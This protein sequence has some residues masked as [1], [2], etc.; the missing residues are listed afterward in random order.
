M[1]YLV[2]SGSLL[3]RAVRIRVWATMV[4]ISVP[5]RASS[6]ERSILLRLEFHGAGKEVN[7]PNIRG[8]GTKPFGPIVLFIVFTEI[9]SLVVPSRLGCMSLMTLKI[10]LR[11]LRYRF[12]CRIEL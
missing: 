7:M 10:L 5:V 6:W 3:R 4:S 2:A 9:H 12:P 11:A 8:D 1:R